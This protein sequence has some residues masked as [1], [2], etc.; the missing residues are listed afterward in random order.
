MN[1]ELPYPEGVDISIGDTTGQMAY[2]KKVPWPEAREVEEWT[3]LR[4]DLIFCANCCLV[5][6]DHFSTVDESEEEQIVVR[7]LWHAAVVAYV[8]LRS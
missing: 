3:S 4:S 5:A 2:L 1:P 8:A 7:G 6:L